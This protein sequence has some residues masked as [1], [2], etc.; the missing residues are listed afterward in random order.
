MVSSAGYV[1]IFDT[2][3]ALLAGI[4]IIPAVFAQGAGTGFRSGASFYH[5]AGRDPQHS[6]RAGVCHCIL[7]G[8]SVCG[9]GPPLLNLLESP[10]EALQSRFGWSRKASLALVGAV[11]AGVGLF[12]EGDLLSPWMDSISIY[13]IPLGALLAGITMFWIGGKKFARDAVQLG[14]KRRLGRWFEPMTRYV[15]CGVALG[16]YIL[17]NF[18]WRN[19]LIREILQ[20]ANP[21]GQWEDHCTATWQ[22]AHHRSLHRKP[23][24]MP[25]AP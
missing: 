18:L 22:T 1:V 24:K 3:S 6:L 7:C 12:V 9:N 5:H 14:R 10:V 23:H 20:T 2:I 8:G 21:P 19:R 25:H 4:V 17:G 16:V 15:F 11:T 13:V